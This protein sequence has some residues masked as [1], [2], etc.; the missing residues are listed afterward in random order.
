MTSRTVISGG[1][2][3]SVANRPLVS[4]GLP[5]YNGEKYL[6][7]ALRSLLNQTYP[8][9]E[10]IICDNASTDA[11]QEICFKYA[12]ID[13]RVRYFRNETNIGGANNHNLCVELA[14][15]KYFRWAA[16][17]DMLAPELIEK[18]VDVLERN[19]HIV[20]CCSDCLLIDERSI[21]NDVY[22]CISGATPDAFERF[23]QLVGHHYCYEAHGLMRRDAMVRTGLLRNYP[24]SDHVLLAH[25]GLFGEFHR[26]EEPLFEKRRHPEMSTQMYPDDYDRYAW[27]GEKYKN[28]LTP[29]HLRQFFLRSLHAH[30]FPS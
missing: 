10:I 28:N 22:A 15:G 12:Y 3:R 24:S 23:V 21:A 13:P 8:E 20:L 18:S 4:I 16:C 1:E 27:Y 9:I 17:D 29:P 2:V 5:V 11:T 25:M 30:R 6:D 14:E 7:Q 26:I 19:A